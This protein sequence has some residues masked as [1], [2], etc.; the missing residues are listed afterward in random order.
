MTFDIAT[1]KDDLW[2]GK[3]SRRDFKRAL[4]SAGLVMSTLPMA[5]RPARAESDH[6]T[7]F[8]GPATKCRS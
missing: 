5:S 3:M 8:R 7:F 2:S 4:A 6:P 1:F